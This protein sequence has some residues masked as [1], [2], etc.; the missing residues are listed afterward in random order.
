MSINILKAKVTVNYGMRMYIQ[1]EGTILL[2][3][4][5]TCQ[6]SAE[7]GSLCDSFQAPDFT[8]SMKIFNDSIGTLYKIS[9]TCTIYLMMY[10]TAKNI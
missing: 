2:W 7:H 10:W 4:I 8:G 1:L 3:W 5:F 9:L 6:C